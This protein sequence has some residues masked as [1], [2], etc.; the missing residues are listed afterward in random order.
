MTDA[1]LDKLNFLEPFSLKGH[2]WALG[3]SRR[4]ISGTLHVDS[5]E[6]MRLDLDG[7]LRKHTIPN[8]AGFILGPRN[9]RTIL[10]QLDNG[11]PVS[12]FRCFWTSHTGSRSS[13]IS[14]ILIIGSHARSEASVRYSTSYLSM[15]NLEEWVDCNPFNGTLPLPGERTWTITCTPPPP[16][17]VNVPGRKLQIKVVAKGSS[18]SNIETSTLTNRFFLRMTRE[19]GISQRHFQ[20]LQ[21]A[22]R[23]LVSL[24]AGDGLL[25]RQIGGEATVS[26]KVRRTKSAPTKELRALRLFY[27]QRHQSERRQTNTA[28]MLFPFSAIKDQFETVCRNW[29]ASLTRNAGIYDVFFTTLFDRSQYLETRFFNLAQCLEAFHRKWIAK[30][31]G[32]FVPQKR[33]KQ[34]RSRVEARLPARLPRG[35]ESA[36]KRVLPQANE[37]SFLERLQALFVSLQPETIAMVTDDP[38]RFMQ[39]IRDTRNQFTHLEARKKSKAFAREQWHQACQKMQLILIVHFLKLCGIEESLIRQRLKSSTRFNVSPFTFET[40]ED[41]E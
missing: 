6:E 4:K 11:T 39:A 30:G 28:Q 9:E 2:W 31:G 40:F 26:T 24:L 10:G 33:F 36:F 35:L 32:K 23:N 25:V 16:F 38:S 15:T 27:V 8:Y 41:A 14:N 19:G 20:L 12:L 17:V 18:K 37:F 34:I 22:I 5:N 3:N 7:V 1:E 13:H 29:F 21:A